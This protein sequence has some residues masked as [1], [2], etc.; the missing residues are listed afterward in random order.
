MESGYAYLT[1][2]AKSKPSA[3]NMLQHA[4]NIIRNFA[5]PQSPQEV[6]DAPKQKRT[7]NTTPEPDNVY[8][9]VVL[10]TRDLLYVMELV[11]AFSAGDFGRVEDILPDLA[12]MFRGASS[13]N[14]STE[15]LHLIFNLKEVWTPE[16]G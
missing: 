16:F 12:S 11:N 10:L 1:D 6:L 7:S 3:E 15:I 9:N 8:A 2:Y 4:W 14:Y 5:T 13:N